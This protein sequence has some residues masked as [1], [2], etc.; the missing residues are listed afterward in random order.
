MA[1][2]VF[3]NNLVIIAFLTGIAKLSLAICV[4]NF[5]LGALFGGRRYLQESGQVLGQKNNS[6][7]IW[8]AL[9]FKNPLVAIYPQVLA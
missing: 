4:A 1:L 2:L 6:F 3:D 9:M 8:I 5:S 7:V